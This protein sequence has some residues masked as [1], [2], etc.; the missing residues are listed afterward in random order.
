MAYKQPRVPE[1]TGGALSEYIKTLV[2]FLRDFCAQSWNADKMK[3]E[4]ISAIKKRLDAL[5]GK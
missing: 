5:E 4:E 3:D 1:A 2:R